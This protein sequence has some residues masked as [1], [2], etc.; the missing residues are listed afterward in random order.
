[1]KQCE[2]IESDWKPANDGPDDETSVLVG[3][4]DGAVCEGYLVA[5]VWRG[6]EG[7]PFNEVPVCWRHMPEVPEGFLAAE[8]RAP[9][10]VNG[11][12]EEV[13]P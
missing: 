11:A 9:A 7:I 2:Q 8:H 4:D 12:M 10:P 1:M 13:L 3:F 6:S 5:G